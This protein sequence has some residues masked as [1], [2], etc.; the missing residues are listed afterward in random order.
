MGAADELSLMELLLVWKV[1]YLELRLA[2]L[3][4]CISCPCTGAGH[5]RKSR[6][7]D[8]PVWGRVEGTGGLTLL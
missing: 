7:W 2:V 6:Q 3:C 4:S 5:P 1:R 8:G